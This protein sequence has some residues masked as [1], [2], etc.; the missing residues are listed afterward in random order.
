MLLTEEPGP[1]Y[2]YIP[3]ERSDAWL[4]QLTAEQPIY[5]KKGGVLVRK[6]TLPRG[7]ANEAFDCTIYAFAALC[8]LKAVRGL[9]ME[10]AA[11]QLY[12]HN[13]KE[14]G[15]ADLSRAS[16]TPWLQRPRMASLF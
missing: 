15:H 13:T 10:R 3:Q 7:R 4:G 8:G 2:F 16:T 6:W 11:L 14:C 9:N 1:G 12:H 5:E